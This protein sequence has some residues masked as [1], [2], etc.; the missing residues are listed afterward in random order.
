MDKPQTTK[1]R[2]V[3]LDILMV[4]IAAWGIFL[5]NSIFESTAFGFFLGTN[6]AF[7]IVDLQRYARERLGAMVD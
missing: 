5:S 1:L 3:I 7:A 4:L 6:T 2:E